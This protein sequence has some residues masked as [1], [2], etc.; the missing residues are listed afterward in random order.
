ML[1]GNHKRYH[2]LY[3]YA[4]NQ[5]HPALHQIE[6][7]AFIGCWEEEDLA[8]LFFHLP[9]DALVER[10]LARLGLKLEDKAE[11]DYA[12]WGEGRRIAPFHVGPLRFAP[13]W[14]AREDDLRFDPGVVFG[15]GTHPTTRLCLEEL[16]RLWEQKGPFNKVADLG[17]GSGL[18]SLLA[19]QLGAE[20]FAVDINPLCVELTRK[21]LQQNQLAH[22]AQ[23]LQRDVRKVLP[24]TSEVVVAN[25]F[26]GLLLELFGL[27]SFWQSKYY[28]FTGFVPSMEEELRKALE[29]YAERLKR[30]E[31]EGW[32][33]YLVQAKNIWRER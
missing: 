31:R 5:K 33:L 24:L 13:E 29:P 30:T 28:L 8:V 9:R 27:P 17:C 23:V 1:R 18:V 10:T 32:V 16:Y 14:M 11:V 7:E 3:L 15:S 19:A 22:K 21:N 20:V 4:V 12:E 2:K 6:D 25:L 26:K